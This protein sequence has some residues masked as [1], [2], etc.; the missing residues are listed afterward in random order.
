MDL[1]VDLIGVLKP[2]KRSKP[3][4]R[5]PDVLRLEE[6]LFALIPR[7]KPRNRDIHILGCRAI[8]GSDPVRGRQ[9]LKRV[10]RFETIKQVP[11]ALEPRPP[12]RPRRPMPF[13]RPRSL[14]AIGLPCQES[15]GVI[16][17]QGAPDALG[18]FRSG[19]R[20]IARGCRGG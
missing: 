8:L 4:P 10:R 16:E 7:L 19:E 6:V 14:T 17:R 9:E 15:L 20:G 2:A 11:N 3:L 5:L 13:T 1:G 12:R 18:D